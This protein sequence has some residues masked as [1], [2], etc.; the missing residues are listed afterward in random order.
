LIGV[1]ELD[2]PVEHTWFGTTLFVIFHTLLPLILSINYTYL[3][4]Q[5]HSK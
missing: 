5:S 1:A 4:L 2:T 3:L